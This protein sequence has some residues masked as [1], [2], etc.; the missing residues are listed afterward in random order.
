MTWRLPAR[1]R[2][3]LRRPSRRPVGWTV[4]Y[5]R[6][7]LKAGNSLTFSI[8]PRGQAVNR[9]AEKNYEDFPYMDRLFRH[10]RQAVRTNRGKSFD[11]A[12]ELCYNHMVVKGRT[13]P[14]EGDEADGEK[15]H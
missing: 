7:F 9:N 13:P 2:R 1:A 6:S 11:I 4:S 15:G 8:E 10:V 5:A 12:G 14:M 3:G